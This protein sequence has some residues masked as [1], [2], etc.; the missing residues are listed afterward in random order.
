MQHVPYT[1]YTTTAMNKQNWQ[2]QLQLQKYVNIILRMKLKLLL[3]T[4]INLN[5]KF[6]IIY[7]LQIEGSF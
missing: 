6:Y 3:Y 5:D 2:C 1:Q 4:V 7:N